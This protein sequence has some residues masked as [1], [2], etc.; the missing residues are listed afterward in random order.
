MAWP[1]S[2]VI[3]VSAATKR[4]PKLCPFS[5]SPPRKRWAKS[6]A[7][8]SSSS[9]RA[10]MQLR[11]SPG[12]SMLKP[13]RR[14]PEEPPSS[15]TET[16]AARSAITPCAVEGWLEAVTCRRSP[17][18]SVERPVPPP[19][20]T[21]RRAGDAEES[22]LRPSFPENE[23]RL[24]VIDWSMFVIHSPPGCKAEKASRNLRVQQ[25]GKARI[26][27]HALEVV[28]GARLE[29]VLGIQFDGLRKMLQA[30]L[31]TPCDRVQQRE[32]V[33]S[34]IGPRMIGQNVEELLARILEVAGIQQGHGVVAMLLRSR[35]RQSGSLQLPLA[36]LDIH[37]A[38][39][40]D[41]GR[42]SGNHLFKTGQR[43]FILSLLQQLHSSLKVLEDRSGARKGVTA[44]LGSR[45]RNF[46][47]ARSRGSCLLHHM[48]AENA[49]S[50]T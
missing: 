32:P 36:G 48:F 44:A 13:L 20:A 43:S 14:R 49:P 23:S 34:V 5:A 27:H 3:S 19:I 35:E 17:R 42:R 30:I 33:K 37:L 46:L 12:G 10:T 8:R 45:R 22:P 47:A 50:W 41:L 40:F 6:R 18:S 29:P 2:P 26:V 7:S 38:A 24:G 11:R 9:L 39:L 1:K 31:R 28:V 4:L 15:V 16:T 25:L 21:T